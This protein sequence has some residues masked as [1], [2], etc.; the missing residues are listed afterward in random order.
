MREL[1]NPII[2]LLHE[3]TDA[4]AIYDSSVEEGHTGDRGH[5]RNKRFEHD[6]PRA[7][8]KY[9]SLLLSYVLS[10]FLENHLK[11]CPTNKTD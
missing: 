10:K 1:M 8:G 3:L 2:S 11:Y 5:K 4:A 7:Q 9:D 6:S